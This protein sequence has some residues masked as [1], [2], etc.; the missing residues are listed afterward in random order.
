MADMPQV[1][2]IEDGYRFKGGDPSKQESW[3]PVGPKAAPAWGAGAMELPD[4]SIVRYGPRGGATVLKKPGGGGGDDVGALTEDQGKAQ[5]YARLMAGA[6]RNYDRAVREGYRPDSFKN[7]MASIL[8]GLPFGGLD[9]LGMMVRDD[10]SDRGRQAELQWSDAQLKAVSGAASPE[11][12]VKR[13]VKTYFAR[14]GENM[15]AIAGQKKGARS[16]AFDAAR[17]RS[18]P[19]AKA[20]AAP[21]TDIPLGARRAYEARFNSGKIDESKP[22]GDPAR[23]YVA[24]DAQTM[25]RLPAGAYVITP[26][27]HYAVIE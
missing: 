8:E 12:E 7:T 15:A 24:K 27:G 17:V 26:E 14:P 16:T 10:V 1:G 3:E 11:P 23:P 18:G 5:T 4:G 6:E 9:G 22:W 25:D 21:R 20:V 19:A 2:A 13:N